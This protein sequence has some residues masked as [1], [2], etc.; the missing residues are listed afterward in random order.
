MTVPLGCILLGVLL[1]LIAL[2]RGG[3]APLLKLSGN[4]GAIYPVLPLSFCAIGVAFLLK[5]LL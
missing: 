1:V 3:R 2:E 5:S 4:F